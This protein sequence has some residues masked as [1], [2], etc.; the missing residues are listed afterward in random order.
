MA[1]LEKRP[2]LSRSVN[3]TTVNK[4]IHTTHWEKYPTPS[5]ADP[6]SSTT[7]PSFYSCVLGRAV[8]GESTGSNIPD[9]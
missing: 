6:H 3:F 5:S 8:S 1:S 4:Y 7:R 9:E 2:G